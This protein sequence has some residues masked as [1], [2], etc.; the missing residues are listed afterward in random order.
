MPCTFSPLSCKI[1]VAP[2]SQCSHAEPCPAANNRCL[3][4]FDDQIS[5]LTAT[6]YTQYPF[7]FLH[8]QNL[9]SYAER[10]RNAGQ[11]M[12]P[13]KS[14]SKTA[15]QQHLAATSTG[16]LIVHTL[17]LAETEQK[18]GGLQF[19]KILTAPL[20]VHYLI[21]ARPVDEPQLLHLGAGSAPGR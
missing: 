8:Y 10:T 9:Y 14:S 17:L 11:A 21:V 20:W 3:S 7:V 16:R 19:L 13:L 12:P 15:L 4:S 1:C 5:L 2:V 6:T 18:Q